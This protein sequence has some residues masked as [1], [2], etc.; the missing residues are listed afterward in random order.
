MKKLYFFAAILSCCLGF[1][2]TASNFNCN[3][4]SNNNHDLFADLDAGKV[5]VIIWVMPCVTCINGA[6][7]A[8][9]E[10]QNALLTHPGRVLYYVADDNGNTNCT[11]LTN[12]ANA[13]G[14]TDG[15]I[16]SDTKVSMAPYGIAGMPKIIVIGG[17]DHKVFYNQNAP[18]ITET[19]IKDAIASALSAVPTAL[20]EPQ[21]ND[22][23][24]KIYPNPSLITSKVFVNL[25]KSSPVK[26]EVFNQLGQVVTTVFNGNLE[27]GN[28]SFDI[29]TS[30]LSNGSYFI[31]FSN[32]EKTFHEKFIVNH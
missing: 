26:I 21:K 27:I 16:I 25:I 30:E 22:F 20:I 19:G 32:G 8:Q 1:S 10:V 13:N 18:S 3:D 5:V 15:I 2:Q 11:T 9:T 14:V 12:W 28:S 24:V 4:C 31:R 29:K 7:T 17:T 6:L 23:S